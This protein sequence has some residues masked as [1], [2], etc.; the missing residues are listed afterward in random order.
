[1]AT[2]IASPRSSGQPLDSRAWNLALAFQEVF[3]AI[4]RLRSGKQQIPNAEAFR[5]HV[6][7][8]L[9]AAQQDAAGQRFSPETVDLAT[10]AVAAFLDE[11]VLNSNNP[12][13]SDWPR[14]P[15]QEEL[16]GD[17]M[18]G[19]TFFQNIKAVLPRPDSNEIADLLEVYLLCL[20][21]G[22]RGRYGAGA[23]A[24]LRPITDAML[25]KI[26]RVR[27]SMANLSPRWA[28]PN[29]AVRPPESDPW[30]RRLLIGAIASLA[31]TLVLFAAYKFGVI[32]GASDLVTLAT[33][34][35]S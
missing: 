27:G 34:V 7:Q 17:H 1:M 24:E 15:L 19:E 21:L 16:F 23:A 32:S 28:V 31:L 14:L 5:G 35:R 29:D 6:K 3:T 18:A 22:Y 12:V 13:F 9:A 25:D 8:A 30:V 11:S 33:Q 4:I 2:S 20:L 26:R 10:F